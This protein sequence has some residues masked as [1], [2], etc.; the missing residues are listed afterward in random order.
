MSILVGYDGSNVSKAAIKLA[1]EHAALN[2]TTVD[3]IS[4]MQ[5]SPTFKYDDIHHLERELEESIRELVKDNKTKY[6]THLIVTAH[7]AGETLVEF[8]EQHQCREMIIGVR[9]RSK[10]GKLVFGSTAQYVILNAH[11]PVVTIK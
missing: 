9:K 1:L 4:V 3:I 6:K 10:V 7:S 8:A 2:Q 11:C 5:Q